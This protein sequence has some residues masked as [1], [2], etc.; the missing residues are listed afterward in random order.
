MTPLSHNSQKRLEHRENQTKYRKMT[1]KPRSHVR[2]LIYPMWAIDILAYS[3][4]EGRD[5]VNTLH[6]N[7]FLQIILTKTLQRT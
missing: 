2:I 4:S 1:R 6:Y 3:C 7:I 5:L